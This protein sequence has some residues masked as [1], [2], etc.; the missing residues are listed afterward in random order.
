MD[1]IFPRNTKTIKEIYDNFKNDQLIIDNSYQRR[2]VWLLQDKVRLIETILLNLIIPEI[3]LWDCDIDPDTGATIRHI[4]DGQQ[5]INAII[6]FI[7]CDYRLTEKYL[8]DEGIKSNFANYSFAELPSEI[9]RH[10][11]G[12]DLS[13][14]NIDK[15]CNKRDITNLFYRLNLTDYSLNEQEKRN[16]LA[17]EFG[18]ASEQLANMDFWERHKVFSPADIRRMKDVEF[19]GNILILAREG[20]ID[21]TNPQKLNQVYD[22]LKEDYFDK[23]TDLQRIKTAMDIIDSI[24]NETTSS[25][26]SKKT[27][28]YSVFSF[29]L[30][31]MDNSIPLSQCIIDKFTTFVNTYNNFKN[32]KELLFEDPIASQIYENIKR[33]K[34]A[35]SEGINKIGNRMIRFEVLKKTCIN[36]EDKIIEYLKLV[37]NALLD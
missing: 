24:T 27:Q 30:D 32:E 25:F 12:Y 34:L 28:I 31:M 33:Y 14:V 26:I 13:I 1:F 23:E 4:V 5:R 20:I 10:I 29:V 17:S 9:K 11:W 6:D 15:R 36:N 2:K 35:S 37:N 16:S 21:Q 22:D 18:N 19:S 3:F 8:L 7:C